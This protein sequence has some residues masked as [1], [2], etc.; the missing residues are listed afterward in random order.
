MKKYL[1]V[2]GAPNVGKTGA[3]CRLTNYLLDPV[4][5][6]DPEGKGFKL[7]C[8]EIGNKQYSS[9]EQEQR[10]FMEKIITIRQ[11][12][13][14]K[15]KDFRAI[16]N[17]DKGIYI[18]INSATD[19]SFH[20]QKFQAFIE[21]FIEENKGKTISIIISSIQDNCYDDQKN[22]SI[23]RCCDTPKN[24]RNLRKCFFCKL[25]ISKDDIVIELLLAKI[26]NEDNIDKM[27]KEYEYKIDKM[28]LKLVKGLRNC[29]E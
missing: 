10:K 16:L 6:V 21:K 12:Q 9:S 18:A 24:Q 27:L 22:L 4:D 14:D 25:G 8:A 20:I 1:L 23:R 2:G 11:G 7:F 15:Y 3:I 29:S 5:P 28:L 26:T 17:N 13:N 19:Y